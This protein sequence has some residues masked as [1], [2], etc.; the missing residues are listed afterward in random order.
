VLSRIGKELA[1]QTVFPSFM[2]LLVI[3]PAVLLL[4]VLLFISPLMIWLNLRRIRIDMH[5][6][7]TALRESVDR[8][9]GGVA[10]AAVQGGVAEN[11]VV[12]PEM[13]QADAAPASDKIGFS[14]PE[15]GKFFEGPATLAET[16][17]TC[18]EC[19]TDFHI[20]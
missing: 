8:L 10:P 12:P 7:L 14:C 16:T 5:A 18:P 9:S 17:F 13:P 11:A 6:D 3:V 15:C 2:F 1:M 4:C 20:H 19:H